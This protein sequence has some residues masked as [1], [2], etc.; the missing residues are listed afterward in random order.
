[1]LYTVKILF[2][3]LS[4]FYSIAWDSQSKP[5]ILFP[6]H[7]NNTSI[8]ICTE[9]YIM[10]NTST[11]LQRFCPCTKYSWRGSY[12]NLCSPWFDPLTLILVQLKFTSGLYIPFA[13]VYNMFSCTN[14]VNPHRPV[15]TGVTHIFSTPS[16]K[17]RKPAYCRNW[18]Q[19]QNATGWNKRAAFLGFVHF[20]FASCRFVRSTHDIRVTVLLYLHS[21]GWQQCAHSCRVHAQKRNGRG[22]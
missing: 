9:L 15:T 6:F 3:F 5:H 10:V 13:L 1:M 12:L 21:N 17:K 8:F 18:K 14:T 20:S 2:F 19:V 22:T 7:F 4:V 16:S 11:K